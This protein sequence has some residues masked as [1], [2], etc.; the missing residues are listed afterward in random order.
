[1]MI[2]IGGSPTLAGSNPAIFGAG[3]A[4]KGEYKTDAECCTIRMDRFSCFGGKSNGLTVRLAVY[5]YFYHL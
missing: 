1:M 4:R 5:G 3:S 2:S